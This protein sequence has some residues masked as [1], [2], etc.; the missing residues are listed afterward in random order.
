MGDLVR[1]KFGLDDEVVVGEA[2]ESLTLIEEFF[3][4]FLAAGERA[5]LAG[6]A[7]VEPAMVERRL[8]PDA[9]VAALFDQVT[10]VGNSPG[11]AAERE[12]AAVAVGEGSFKTFGL[13]NAELIDADAVDYVGDLFAQVLLDLG[14]E[15]DAMA[16][17]K[18]CHMPGDAR[19]ADSH[20]AGQGDADVRPVNHRTK[21]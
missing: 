4:G 14:V 1:R 10:I 2:V 19:L 9:F 18:I 7:D 16:V 12:D 6:V 17:E 21:L 8:E 3:G 11:A 20:E 13:D 15:V 5:F